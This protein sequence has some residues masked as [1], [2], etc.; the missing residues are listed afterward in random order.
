MIDQGTE[1]ARP[2]IVGTDQPQPVDPLRVGE[3]SRARRL[4]VHAAPAPE[5]GSTRGRGEGGLNVGPRHVHSVMRP[6]EEEWGQG[7][8][9]GQNEGNGVT[10]A[11]LA[12]RLKKNGLRETEAGI[13][14]KLK[15]GT[16]AATFFLACLAA[17]ELEGV[18]LEEA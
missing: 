13:T 10:Y 15:R 18:V 16:F 2:D 14:M 3:V 8:P 17:M 1:G 12:K 9:Q 5:C 7:L 4:A 11:E 6:V